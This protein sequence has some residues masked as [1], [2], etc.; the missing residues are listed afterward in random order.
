M[1]D[2]HSPPKDRVEII[3]GGLYVAPDIERLV[4]AE[5]AMLWT[6]PQGQEPV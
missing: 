5:K 6:E 2:R 4:M 3:D 1:D